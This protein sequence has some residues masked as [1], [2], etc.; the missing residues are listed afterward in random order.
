MQGAGLYS[1]AHCCKAQ[2]SSKCGGSRDPSS[3][4]IQLAKVRMTCHTH[5]T[6]VGSRP[7]SM[8]PQEGDSRCMRERACLVTGSQA[9]VWREGGGAV[10][11]VSLV[12]SVSS[13]PAEQQ[14]VNSSTTGSCKPWGFAIC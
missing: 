3:R 12:S 14:R 6:D 13:R 8:L 7:S 11:G 9:C 1:R 10:I 2:R 5:G 4:L